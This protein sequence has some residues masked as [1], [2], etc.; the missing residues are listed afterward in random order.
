MAFEEEV[1]QMLI[2]WNVCLNFYI[3]QSFISSF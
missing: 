3:F 2:F 1:K